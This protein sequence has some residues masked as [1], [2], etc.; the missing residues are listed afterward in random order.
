[1]YTTDHLRARREGLAAFVGLLQPARGPGAGFLNPAVTMP[2]A[3]KRAE[4]EVS[5]ISY[6][7]R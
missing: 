6:A 1:V 4:I 5:V 7:L 2:G 3:V